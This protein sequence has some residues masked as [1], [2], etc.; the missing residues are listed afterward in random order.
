[1]DDNDYYLFK[2]ILKTHS[3]FR[4]YWNIRSPLQIP[5]FEDFFVF[6]RKEVTIEEEER[7]RYSR[8]VNSMPRKIKEYKC[9]SFGRKEDERNGFYRRCFDQLITS[10]DLIEV[11]PGILKCKYCRGN[12]KEVSIEEKE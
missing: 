8:G 11:R 12:I 5:T 4:K 9:S 7:E 1:M 2:L 10:D 6:I 3:K